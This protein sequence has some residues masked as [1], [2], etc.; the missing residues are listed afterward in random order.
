MWMAKFW[1]SSISMQSRYIKT[2]ENWQENPTWK[3]SPLLAVVHSINKVVIRLTDERWEHILAGH[4]E[5]E[6]YL[7]QILDVV[8]SPRMVLHCREDDFFVAGSAITDECALSHILIALYKEINKRD[9]FII[10]A[11]FIR[12]EKMKRRYKD[13]DP[14]YPS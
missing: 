1:V 9:G 10:S 3:R 13:C 5:V 6:K 14:V 12:S 4:P 7:F 11:Y 8:E 2:H